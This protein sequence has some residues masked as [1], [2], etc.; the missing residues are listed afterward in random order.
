VALLLAEA[1]VVLALVLANGFLAMGEAAFVAARTE[2]LREH[3]DG[4]DAGARAALAFKEDPTRFLSTVQVGIT[5]VG[6]LAG[7]FGGAT[8]AGPLAGVLAG[9]PVLGG[10]ARPVAFAAVVVAVSY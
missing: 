2:R 10:Y 1:L 5:L 9:V 8:F 4:G 3:A 7:A 6:V